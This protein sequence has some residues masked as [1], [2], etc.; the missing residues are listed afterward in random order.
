M[1]YSA[2]SVRATVIA[3]VAVGSTLLV[4]TVG[5]V[6]MS[7]R[8]GAVVAG[9]GCVV[10]Y[11]VAL[12]VASM[13]PA[14]RRPRRDLAPGE[15]IRFRNKRYF[16]TPRNL[17]ATAGLLPLPA[18]VIGVGTGPWAA[19]VFVGAVILGS[20][21]FVSTVPPKG[22]W[23]WYEVTTA[24]LTIRT[25]EEHRVVPWREVEYL[26]HRPRAQTQEGVVMPTYTTHYDY[27]ELF[28]RRRG[29]RTHGGRQP[30]GPGRRRLDVRRRRAMREGDGLIVIHGVNRQTTLS[31]LIIDQCREHVGRTLR[32]GFDRVGELDYGEFRITR[33]GVHAPDGFLPWRT[34]WRV[35][36]FYKG[37]GIELIVSAPDD[38]QISGWVPEEMIVLDL[39]ETLAEQ[40]RP[41]P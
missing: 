1:A 28:L 23:R 25:P 7:H 33:D 11:L 24:G 12:G 35:L 27:L 37:D 26:C 38:Q 30:P 39:L 19:G 41:P 17:I 21:V 31:K 15:T 29:P 8:A 22:G 9:A 14:R 5:L 13:A 18:L 3:L 16:F 34:D 40:R 36:H 4:I 6:L 2:R 32:A 10:F 20:V